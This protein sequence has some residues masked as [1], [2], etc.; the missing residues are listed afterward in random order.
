MSAE[1]NSP[2]DCFSR[3]GQGAKRREDAR[4]CADKNPLLSA[5]KPAVI[6]IELRRAFSMPENRL[7]SRLLPFLSINEPRHRA[8]LR[9][10]F[11]RFTVVSA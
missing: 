1:E 3:R 7:K 4:E 6:L 8:F 9:R 10:G 5:I 11:V 2:V